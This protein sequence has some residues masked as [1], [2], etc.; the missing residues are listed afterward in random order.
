MSQQIVKF[1][2]G[3]GAELADTL[4]L[5]EVLAKSGFFTDS[6]DACQAVVKVLAGRELGIGPVTAMTGIY[7]VKGRVTLSA[8]LMAAAIRRSGRYDYRVKR[9]DATACEIVFTDSGT[10][11]GTS[12]F[13][14]KDAEN[15]GLTGDN[16]RKFPR[17][18]LFA[19]AMSNGAKWYCPDVFGGPVYTRDE[20]DDGSA[21]VDVEPLPERNQ[22][23]IEAP[24]KP[25]QAQPQAIGTPTTVTARS[26]E[27][28]RYWLRN[29]IVR[30]AERY[31]DAPASEKQRA[32]IVTLLRQAYNGVEI[33]P[34]EARH[35]ALG[36]LVG[37]P[38]SK[39][40]TEAQ[41]RALFDL[42]GQQRGTDGHSIIPDNRLIE[43]HKVLHAAIDQRMQ[44]RAA[45]MEAQGVYDGVNDEEMEAGA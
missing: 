35:L 26:A 9:L 11:I 2:G 31:G 32:Y 14:I 3:G 34:D 33:S 37:N 7:I 6:R 27:D 15:A 10:E 21:T 20:L 16:W 23:Q 8:N 42:I 12:S 22:Q 13:S 36:W 41:A 19:R 4:K 29:E 44:Q 18:M 38:S 17:N 43:L 5:G 24:Q 40:L 25:A 45:E 28:V 39:A 1:D 30:H